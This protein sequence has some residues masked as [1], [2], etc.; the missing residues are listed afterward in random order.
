MCRRN[1]WGSVL[2]TR[3]GAVV[4]GLLSPQP[5]FRPISKYISWVTVRGLRLE[6]LLFHPT[7]HPHKT[8]DVH[9]GVRPAKLVL[10]TE[11]LNHI[12][13]VCASTAQ[14]VHPDSASWSRQVISC[15][16][17]VIDPRSA[18]KYKGG[19]RTVMKQQ[20]TEAG[21]KSWRDVAGWGRNNEHWFGPRVAAD[22]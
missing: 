15:L 5:A 3:A 8:A 4:R 14:D 6:G 16:Q 9:F 13:S 18:D 2:P 7:C 20:G 10:E 1:H 19:Q 17:T 12:R 22:L 11:T 21:C